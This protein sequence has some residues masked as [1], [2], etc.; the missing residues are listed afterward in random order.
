MASLLNIYAGFTAQ[1]S[2]VVLALDMEHANELVKDH[3][4][5]AFARHRD[6]AED[7]DPLY[8]QL[9]Q[10]VSVMVPEPYSDILQRWH[11]DTT[12]LVK[13]PVTGTP[14]MSIAPHS[15]SATPISNTTQQ[16]MAAEMPRTR[17]EYWRIDVLSHAEPLALVSSD[18]RHCV[19]RP[20]AAY[21]TVP[22]GG[23]QPR[24]AAPA[25]ELLAQLW[26]RGL[27]ELRH[28]PVEYNIARDE[29][30]PVPQYVIQTPE[31]FW[32]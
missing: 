13:N 14:N 4:R 20:S 8:F 31:R 7:P 21:R 32:A 28:H 2:Y 5:V 23:T 30:L 3:V 1:H 27:V 15:S 12:P 17:H 24:W 22:L 11:I 10:H 16:V 6:I 18:R 19:P 25:S 9:V 29:W 26:D